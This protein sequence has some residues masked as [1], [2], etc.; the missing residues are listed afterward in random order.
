MSIHTNSEKWLIAPTNV[1]S[2]LRA[3]YPFKNIVANT[4]PLKCIPVED[5]PHTYQLCVPSGAYGHGVHAEGGIFWLGAR[6]VGNGLS[7]LDAGK[8]RRSEALHIEFVPSKF[9][10]EGCCIHWKANGLWVSLC[11]HTGPPNNSTGWGSECWLGLQEGGDAVGIY[12]FEPDGIE[13]GIHAAG[14]TLSRCLAL[15]V[16]LLAADPTLAEQLND[17]RQEESHWEAKELVEAVCTCQEGGIVAGIADANPKVA[18]GSYVGLMLAIKIAKAESFVHA[19]TAVLDSPLS[20]SSHPFD[21]H[22]IR[23]SVFF[24]KELKLVAPTNRGSWLRASYAFKDFKDNAMPLTCE[25]VQGSPNTYA[26]YVPACSFSHGVHSGSSRAYWL[27]TT[28]ADNGLRV[29]DVGHENECDALKV[30]FIPAS[31]GRYHW[32]ADG[33]LVSFVTNPGPYDNSGASAAQWL[34]LQPGTSDPMEICVLEDEAIHAGVY[35]SGQALTRCLAL[36][37]LNKMKSASTDPIVHDAVGRLQLE[38]EY[39]QV[40]SLV[41]EVMA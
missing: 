3:V 4:I 17:I 12:A 32:K 23:L 41:K 15:N 28:A 29:L 18:V 34:G 24:G 31:E 22:T 27:G 26:L 35:A 9:G 11:T 7:I 30:Q 21:G 16:L 20:Q 10:G 2:L 5:E 19:L 8:R 14:H 13:V 39:W 38:N 25:A 1:A 6:D 40:A 33:L 37:A 36:S